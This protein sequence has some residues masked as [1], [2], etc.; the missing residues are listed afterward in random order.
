MWCS[1]ARKRE[2]GRWNGL[3]DGMETM[4]EAGGGASERIRNDGKDGG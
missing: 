3:C 2:R 1:V 4:R